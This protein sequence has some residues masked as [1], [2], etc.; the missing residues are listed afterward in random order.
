MRTHGFMKD[1]VSCY[2]RWK[3]GN[4]VLEAGRVAWG[5]APTLRMQ[6]LILIKPPSTVAKSC[7]NQCEWHRLRMEA[8]FS[9]KI[10]G[11]Y[12]VYLC[13]EPGRFD[14]M[15]IC[16]SMRIRHELYQNWYDAVRCDKMQHDGDTM[17]YEAVRWWWRINTIALW[18][19]ENTIGTNRNFHEPMRTCAI[20]YDLCASY[21]NVLSRSRQAANPSAN[22]QRI[23]TNVQRWDTNQ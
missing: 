1:L 16:K 14:T 10:G 5:K 4:V 9:L 22:V 20:Q 8:I 2:K 12:R 15:I 13:A 3:I 17:Q 23:Y 21:C 19:D 7:T 11:S 18:C 6:A